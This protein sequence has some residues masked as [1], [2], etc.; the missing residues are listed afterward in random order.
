MASEWIRVAECSQID[1]D[2]TLAV[3]VNGQEVCLYNLSG[4]FFATD[5]KCTH[6]DASLADGLIQDG[7]LIECPLHEGTFDIRTGKAMS[8]PCTQDI[9]CH[10]VRVDGNAVYL[11]LVS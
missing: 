10:G 4:Q 7:S 8:A 5:N 3:E 11:R 9:R 6:G 2:D 1:E